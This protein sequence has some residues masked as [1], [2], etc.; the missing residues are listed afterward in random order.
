MP[1]TDSLGVP[2]GFEPLPALNTSDSVLSGDHPLLRYARQQVEVNAAAVR[3][4]KA[5]G[6]PSFSIGAATQSLDRVSP[7]NIVTVGASIPL[8][9][10]GV[11]AR[12]KAAEIGRQVAETGVEK[13][14]LEVEAAYRQWWEQYARAEG[15]LDYYRQEGLRYASL[16]LSAAA[17][18]Y[19]A[20]NIGYVE[21]VQNV[22]EA[23]VIREGYLRTVNEY[24]Q[25]VIQ[26]DYF[27]NR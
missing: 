26:I 3:V 18:G 4:E 22:R 25:A 9:N 27:L 21:Y 15:Q 20:G 1:G 23:A 13:A 5:R 16:I 19:R 24:N 14:G 12:V 6:M 11:K 7:Y 17:K 10:Y 2:E 8:F